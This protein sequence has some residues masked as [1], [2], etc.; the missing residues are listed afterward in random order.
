ML[1]ILKAS[2][3]SLHY[4]LQQDSY[5]DEDTYVVKIMMIKSEFL[6]LCGVPTVNLDE[7]L[8]RY[9]DLLYSSGE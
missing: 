7:L 4:K 9:M 8:G 6:D 5:G 1:T 3:C 2:L